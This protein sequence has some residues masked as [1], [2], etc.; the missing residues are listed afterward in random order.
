M[1]SEN[2]R[3]GLFARDAPPSTWRHLP[4]P[5]EYRV[6]DRFER[7]EDE[8]KEQAQV[9]DEVTRHVRR[10]Q[11]NQD[12]RTQVA[13]PPPQSTV[14][15][16]VNRLVGRGRTAN[17][18]APPT[19]TE[20]ESTLSPR[21]ED[22]PTP[23]GPP[24]YVDSPYGEPTHLL[25]IEV[26]RGPLRVVNGL[27]ASV[28]E[29]LMK[30]PDLDYPPERPENP[31]RH[32]HRESWEARNSRPYPDQEPSH[33]EEPQNLSRQE[34]R[35]IHRRHAKEMAVSDMNK[36]L[37]DKPRPPLRPEANNVRSERAGAYQEERHSRGRQD[38][39]DPLRIGHKAP[40]LP[41]GRRVSPSRLHFSQ[42][43]SALSM[44]PPESSV[45]GR[46]RG[47]MNNDGNVPSTPVARDM[48]SGQRRAGQRSAHPVSQECYR[49][50]GG[51]APNHTLPKG[52]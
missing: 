49:G 4:R 6:G 40:P 26:P 14:R 25:T 34:Q 35:R 36:P 48:Q 33:S 16:F 17:K 39:P 29:E 43:H 32:I 7:S 27:P 10:K 50:L 51:P 52:T 9:E 42:M 20:Q 28:E 30:L 8:K 31:L 24:D 2:D 22:E 44:T 38:L 18:D 19:M 11:G 41:V 37:P 21:T 3:P 5:G 15:K 46:E 45:D 12:L 1:V 13:K 23:S 47:L